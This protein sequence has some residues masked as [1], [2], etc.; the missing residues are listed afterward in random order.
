M[1]KRKSKEG[2]APD[3]KPTKNFNSSEMEVLLQEVNTK[4]AV[5]C[6][7]ISRGYKITE[8]KD[9]CDDITHS[10][11]AVSGEGHRADEVKKKKKENGLI[12]N[13]TPRKK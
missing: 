6:S 2:G 11:N 1:P 12:S 8:K 5:I 10:V 4:R 3:S 13:L 7:N 9:A